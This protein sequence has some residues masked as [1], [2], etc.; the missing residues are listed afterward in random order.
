VTNDFSHEAMD[1]MAV[2]Y[3]LFALDS[4]EE[5]T[6]LEHIETCLRCQ[7]TVAEASAIGGALAMSVAV[8]VPAPA[9]RGRV[10]EAALAARPAGTRS[11]EMPPAVPPIVTPPEEPP[12]RPV[13]PPAPPAEPPTP[14]VEPPAA[15]PSEPRADVVP[16]RDGK[17]RHAATKR[18]PGRAILALIAAILVVAIGAGFVSVVRDRN[19]QRSLAEQR[20]QSISSLLHSAQVA[21]PIADLKTKKSLGTVLASPSSVTFV[22]STLPENDPAKTYVLWGLTSATDPHPVALGVFDVTKT[23]LTAWPV[24]SDPTAHYSKYPVFA[25]SYEP[26]RKAPPAP[27]NVL[28]AGAQ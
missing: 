15:P 27:T 2:G 10:L 12:A 7:R 22:T 14:P 17:A 23:A 3:A 21:V 9:L 18:R 13:E 8:P 26:G 25:V 20:E 24:G 6:F 5:A 11:V 4:A 1:A 19:H 16:I 28:G